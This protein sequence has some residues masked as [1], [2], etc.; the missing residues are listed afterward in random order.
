[1]T[2]TFYCILKFMIRATLTICGQRTI[3]VKKYTMRKL[4]Q[5]YL[6]RRAI[7]G[8]YGCNRMVVIFTTACAI[9]VYNY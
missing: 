4:R 6:L 2:F 1:M 8:K 5:I 9:S 7:K 3:A